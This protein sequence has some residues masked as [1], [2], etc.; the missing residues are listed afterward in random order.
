M[1]WLRTLLMLWLGLGYVDDDGVVRV[2][3]YYEVWLLGQRVDGL[4]TRA[5]VAGMA[6]A[7]VRLA[8]A[9]RRLVQLE[10][11]QAELWAIKPRLATAPRK[12]VIPAQ[13]V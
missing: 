3:S 2:L 9:E 13:G 12:F 8:D 6:S 5:V 4:G 7:D 11:R 10:K 1:N